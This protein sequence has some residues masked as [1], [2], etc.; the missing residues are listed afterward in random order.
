M[1]PD[2][3]R[4]NSRKGQHTPHKKRYKSTVKS[5]MHLQKMHSYLR[6]DE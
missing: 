1:W 5:E 4:H 6:E 3:K 2:H